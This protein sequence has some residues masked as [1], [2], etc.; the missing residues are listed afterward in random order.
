M[1]KLS[2][3]E[4]IE[5]HKKLH[6]ELDELVADFVQHTK[7]RPSTTTVWELMKWSYEQT[8]DPTEEPHDHG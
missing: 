7:A 5:R 6:H 3:A 8:L 1:S 4:H 2:R